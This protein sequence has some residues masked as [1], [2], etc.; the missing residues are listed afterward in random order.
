M[1]NPSRRGFVATA[2][3]AILL[4]SW[5]NCALGDTADPRVAKI[6]PET[7]G[8]DM[9]NH[10]YPAGTQQGPQRGGDPGQSK[11]YHGYRAKQGNP[12]GRVRQRFPAGSRFDL[13]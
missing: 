2:T 3:G 9:H 8:I 4:P 6:V 1:S 12:P 13:R 10:V 11:Q 7:M 5:I